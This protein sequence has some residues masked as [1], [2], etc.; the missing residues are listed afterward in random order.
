MAHLWNHILEGIHD[1]TAL[2]FLILRE[3][4]GHCD[5]AEQGNAEPQLE[6]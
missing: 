3:E 4:T 5:N 2:A 6:I 1:L